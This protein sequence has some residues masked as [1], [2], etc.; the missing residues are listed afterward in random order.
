MNSFTINTGSPVSAADASYFA[1]GRIPR[2]QARRSLRERV[3]D[4]WTPIRAKY[5]A[6]QTTDENA[7]HWLAADDLSART[8][9]SLAVRATLRKRARYEVANNSWAKGMV[10]TFANEVVGTGPRLQIQ[11]PN[12]RANAIIEG[13]WRQWAAAVDLPARL[14]LVAETRLIDGEAFGI[15]AYNPRL[16]CDVKLDLK[17]VEADQITTPF[18]KWGDPTA[19][20]GIRFD[21]YGNPHEYDFLPYHPGGSGEFAAYTYNLTPIVYQASQVLHWFRLERPGQAR[22]I[23]DITPALPLFAQ[24]RRY[25]LA[26]LMAAELAASFA[27]II[28]T[29]LPPGVEAPDEFEPFEVA[30]IVRGMFQMLP[31]GTD[32]TQ[33]RAEQPTANYGEFIDRLLKEIARTFEMPY[34]TATGDSSQYNYSSG[35]LDIQAWIRKVL[36]ERAWHER[37]LTRIMNAWIR[38]AAAIPG[39]L[40]IADLG[41]PQSWRRQWHWDGFKHVDPSK[42]ASANDTELRNLTRTLTELASEDGQ[43]VLEKLNTIAREVEACKSLG[44]THPA[45]APAP[46][47]GGFGAGRPGGEQADSGDKESS[48]KQPAKNATDKANK[49]PTENDAEEVAGATNRE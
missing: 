46:K 29:D 16:E 2:V 49:P 17:L 3:A 27:A 15:F 12:P 48:D 42:E 38:E 26:V 5:D 6:A 10:K 22:G 37:Y 13:R 44:L 47:P 11:T 24:L 31:A 1:A 20:D 30:D 7:K 40:P 34:G 39:Y 8:A 35:R 32:M 21:P 33:F 25:T 43:D 9:N 4:A 19:V 36:I 23:P 41:P 28:K 18:P 14:R 45:S